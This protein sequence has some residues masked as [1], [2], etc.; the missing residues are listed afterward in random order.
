MYMHIHV[1]YPVIG[2]LK[3]NVIK[4]IEF[5]HPSE[6]FSSYWVVPVPVPVSISYLSFL[7][8]NLSP[9]RIRFAQL[10]LT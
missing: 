1:Y 3:G 2:A 5:K 6:R 4:R 9:Y 8:Q 10:D 7:T